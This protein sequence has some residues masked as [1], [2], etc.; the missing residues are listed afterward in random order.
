MTQHPWQP[1]VGIDD[2]SVVCLSSKP[3]ALENKD[4]ARQAMSN[5]LDFI[6]Q[7]KGQGPHPEFVGLTTDGYTFNLLF[8]T[9]RP[10][11]DYFNSDNAGQ[12]LAGIFYLK[13]CLRAQEQYWLRHSMISRNPMLSLM[14]KLDNEH[15]D[16]RG[17]CF[18]MNDQVGLHTEFDNR[19]NNPWLP[20]PEDIAT[21][22]KQC[23]GRPNM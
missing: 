3:S 9:R 17:V 16:A 7:M 13:E 20:A 21:L 4:D 2:Y 6:N 23:A 14:F 22:K 1:A 12:L 8:R 18:L 10:L 5:F 15:V 19:F 11:T